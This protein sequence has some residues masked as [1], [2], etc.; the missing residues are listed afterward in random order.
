MIYIFIF[1]GIF[2][3]VYKLLSKFIEPFKLNLKKDD[4]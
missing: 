1:I 2:T 3:I 4:K